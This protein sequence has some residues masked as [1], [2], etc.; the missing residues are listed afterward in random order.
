MKTF[1][2]W[3]EVG[4]AMRWARAERLFRDRTSMDSHMGPGKT[5]VSVDHRWR[6]DYGREVMVSHNSMLVSV[7]VSI[8]I[9]GNEWE[10]TYNDDTAQVLRVLAALYLIPAELAVPG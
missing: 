3:R 8:G 9:D 7:D 2:G 6:D 1:V 4:R 5:A 10:T